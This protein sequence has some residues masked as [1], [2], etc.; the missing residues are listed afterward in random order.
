MAAKRKEREEKLKQPGAPRPPE[1]KKPRI[2][3]PVSYGVSGF[4]NPLTA[5]LRGEILLALC[6]WR[7]RQLVTARSP[8]QSARRARSDQ[9]CV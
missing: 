6:R 3:K 8:W 5:C 9:R 2:E 7:S 4:A 1:E